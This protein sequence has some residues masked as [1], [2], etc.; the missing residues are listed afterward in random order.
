[1]QDFALKVKQLKASLCGE[2]RE[3]NRHAR[4]YTE[5][6]YFIGNGHITDGV[7]KE[8]ESYPTGL[9]STGSVSL[10]DV[11]IPP[12]ATKSC[13][14]ARLDVCRSLESGLDSSPRRGEEIVGTSVGSFPELL[15]VIEPTMVH[16][17]I[18]NSYE[19]GITVIES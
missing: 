12:R 7:Q 10:P 8:L 4:E 18:N 6:G 5:Q 14:G 17:R 15:L 16:T 19:R 3:G 2:S 9:T 13:Y 11:S 1:M